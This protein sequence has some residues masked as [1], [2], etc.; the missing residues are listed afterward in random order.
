MLKAHLICALRD[1]RYYLSQTNSPEANDT[2][3]RCRLEMDSDFIHA[4]CCFRSY[5]HTISLSNGRIRLW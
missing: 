4:L 1:M 2:L 3:R 5:N